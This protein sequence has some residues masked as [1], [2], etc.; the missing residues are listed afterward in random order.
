MKDHATVEEYYYDISG[1]YYYADVFG[2]DATWT[3]DEWNLCVSVIPTQKLVICRLHI[4]FRQE[5]ADNGFSMCLSSGTTHAAVDADSSK[6][7][8]IGSS[9]ASED[10]SFTQSSFAVLPVSIDLSECPIVG[11]LGQHL[12][13]AE[14]EAIGQENLC[15]AITVGYFKI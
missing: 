2:C 7:A 13:I 9:T 15:P 12:W 3:M 5:G 8:I 14:Y 11:N 6:I 4:A 10:E 1:G